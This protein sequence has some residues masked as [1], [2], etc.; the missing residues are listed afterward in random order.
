VLGAL[1]RS[2]PSKKDKTSGGGGA[3]RWAVHTAGGGV[4]SVK[5][6]NIELLP[7]DEQPLLPGDGVGVDGSKE[8]QLYLTDARW[9]PP[10]AGE[11][12]E[13]TMGGGGTRCVD[14]LWVGHGTRLVRTWD[15]RIACWDLSYDATPGN[16]TPGNTTPG[17]TPGNTTPGNTPGNTPGSTPG[18]ATA[19][20]TPS[21]TAPQLRGT[22]ISGMRAAEGR[23]N[24]LLP[25]SSRHALVCVGAAATVWDVSGGAEDGD[26][27]PRP[28]YTLTGHTRDILAALSP[29]MTADDKASSGP[30]V[31]AMTGDSLLTGNVDA[32]CHEVITIANDDFP[33]IPGS[34]A[35]CVKHWCFVGP[36]AAPAPLDP[37]AMG[38]RAFEAAQHTRLRSAAATMG[39]FAALIIHAEQHRVCRDGHGLAS[40]RQRG[41][42][43]RP[44][45]VGRVGCVQPHRL[46]CAQ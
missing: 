34:F 11:W 27:A 42:A 33:N 45:G 41:K 36:H 5:A 38:K 14:L 4:V 40:H 12:A 30:S 22:Q 37:V 15:N 26:G 31:I 10:P 46:G 18:T 17:N 39:E 43:V 13:V 1:V 7:R 9:A 3:G 20:S 29:R 35:G 8:R 21:P 19:G 2:A 28:L 6:I 16:T 25:V 24:V 32:H 44:R 23:V